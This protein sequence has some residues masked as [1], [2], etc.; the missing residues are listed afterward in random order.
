MS[1]GLECVAWCAENPSVAWRGK[2]PGYQWLDNAQ[3]QVGTPRPWSV[4]CSGVASFRAEREGRPARWT[5]VLDPQTALADEVITWLAD[6]SV[7]PVI[8]AKNVQLVKTAS[9][10]LYEELT[11]TRLSP[12]APRARRRTLTPAPAPEFLWLPAQRRSAA[13]APAVRVCE[14]SLLCDEDNVRPYEKGQVWLCPGHARQRTIER[15]QKPS[16]TPPWPATGDQT[17][18]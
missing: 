5:P 14:A 8:Y 1:A 9:L 18:F 16:A 11:G 17:L 13:P 6:G 15:Q 3:F 12:F 4:R 10:A 7:K 2:V